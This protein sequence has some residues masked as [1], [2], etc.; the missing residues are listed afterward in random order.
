M[1]AHPLLDDTMLPL[2]E[3]AI[4]MYRLPGTLRR[5][6]NQISPLLLLLLLPFEG[7]H[8][9]AHPM[10]R[11][12][13]SCSTSGNVTSGPPSAVGV[14][15]CVTGVRVLL[16]VVVG[17]GVSDEVLV[18]ELLAVLLALPVPLLLAEPLPLA[19]PEPDWLGDPVPDGLPVPVRLPGGLRVALRVGLTVRDP[20][21]LSVGVPE[22]LAPV[23]ALAVDAGV[24]LLVVLLLPVW[25]GELVSDGG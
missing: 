10:D 19:L 22:L 20:L 21:R 16:G 25:E 1:T 8:R 14:G 23:V 15:L 18:S 24:P 17:T 9:D 4:A 2:V 13:P 12:P 6:S 3:G 7:T 11:P 5:K